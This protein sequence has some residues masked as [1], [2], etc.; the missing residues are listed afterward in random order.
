MLKAFVSIIIPTLNRCDLL[1]ETLASVLDQTH[2]DWEA[3][4]VDDGSHD[5]TMGK[6]GALSKKD[7]RI[8][9][10]KRRS[11]RS[12]APVC[13]NEAINA[14][15][16]EYIIHLDSDDCLAPTCLEKRIQI[17]ESHRDL[18][19]GVFPC[20]LFQSRP[21]D[22]QVFWNIDTG[23]NVIDRFLALDVPWITVSSIWRRKAVLN[24]GPWDENLIRFQ[25]WDFYLRALIKGFKYDRYPKPDCFWRY[26]PSGDLHWENRWEYH[27]PSYLFSDE[28]LFSSIHD[29]LTDAGLMNSTKK[30]LIV[31]LHFWLAQNWMFSQH[32]RSEAVRIWTSCF[33]KGLISKR[34][35][36]E[37]LCLFRIWN[38]QKL[39]ESFRKYLKATWPKY[40]LFTDSPTLKN[41]NLN[42]N[43]Q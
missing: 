35:Y 30:S 33:K 27:L 7:S 34:I 9:L 36:L 24:N 18:D 42:C 20:Q 11:S 38:F 28:R 4:I 37:G 21:G 25:D 41:A 1:Q 2:S 43:K 17:M 19:F 22:M 40:A 12:G 32:K 31:G 39:R 3:I 10:L 29:M 23:E 15:T 6:I 8:H 5:E 14:S 16:G 13:R 26:R